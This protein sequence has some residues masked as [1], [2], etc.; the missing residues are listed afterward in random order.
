M[1]TSI[2]CP[3]C[4][5]TIKPTAADTTFYTKTV[6]SQKNNEMEGSTTVEY[7]CPTCSTLIVIPYETVSNISDIENRYAVGSLVKKN[8]N[9]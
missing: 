8:F 5:S 1:F 6:Q 3:R 4:N 2:I 9:L 7:Q